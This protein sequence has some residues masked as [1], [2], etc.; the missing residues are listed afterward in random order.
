MAKQLNRR[1]F[2]KIAAGASASVALSPKARRIALEPFVRPPEEVLPGRATWYATTCGECPAGCGIL[3]RQINGRPRKI[4]GN[5]AHPI[6]RGKVCARGQAGLQRLYNPD[7]LR[8]AVRRM[9]RRGSRSFEPIPWDDALDEVVLGLQSV[10]PPGQV[11]FLGGMMPDHLYDLAS[12]FTQALGAGSPIIFDLH[13]LVEGRQALLEMSRRWFGQRHLPIYDIGETEIVLSFGANFLETW[14]SPVGQSVAYGTMRQGQ[15]GGRGFVA[16]FEPRMSSTAAAA[17]EWIPIRPGTEGL[18][19]LGMG[20]IIVEENLGRVGSHRPHAHLYRDVSVADVALAT[21]IPVETMQRLARSF[22]EA[23]R[24]VAIPGGNLTGLSN[25]EETLDAVMAL[26]VVMRRIGRVGGVFLPRAVPESSFGEPFEPSDYLRIVQFVEE[27][28]W[29][30]VDVLFIHSANPTYDLPL[31]TGF[32]TM[33]R[34]VPLII[35]FSSTVDETAA[36]ADLILPDH[37]PLESW[38]Y[39]YPSPGGDRPTVS[40]YQPTVR[41]LY[42]TRSTGEVLL[43]LAQRL[44]GEAAEALPWPDEATY[45]REMSSSLMG[46]SIG[47]YDARTVEGFWSRWR[48]FGGWWSDR[49]LRAEPETVNLPTDPI[50]VPT[51]EFVA[52]GEEDELHLLVYPSITLAA[53]A[54]AQQPLLQE[55]ADPMTTAR[56]QTWLEIHPDTARD[57]GIH[58]HDLVRVVSTAGEIE[59]PAVIYPG[60]RPDVVAIPMGRGQTDGGRFAENRGVNPAKILSPPPNDRWHEF[61]WGST[62]VRVEPTGMKGKLARLE[63]LEGEGRESIR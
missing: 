6:N 49:E 35:S 29:S 12:R 62:K 44:G 10:D 17:D 41:P 39:R 7:R 13:S 5:P 48:Q 27:L 63:N 47:R 23:D 58:E 55:V 11:A 52:K 9:G 37:T 4:E 18:V 57:R 56:W 30:K 21:D 34:K 42:D 59:L 53:G 8:N 20:R 45:L 1:D 50:E 38:G 3:V 32:E 31:W 28:R 19:A 60:I 61:L 16:H 2:V 46:S 43:Q 24:S 36:F 54:G 25:A 33:L 51:A 40:G 15:L 26:N 14:M 22:A